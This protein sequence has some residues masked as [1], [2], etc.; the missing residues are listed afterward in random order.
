MRLDALD[1]FSS[2]IRCC[3]T[4]ASAHPPS[5][6]ASFSGTSSSSNAEKHVSRHVRHAKTHT[7]THTHTTGGAQ[8]EII[9][10]TRTTT[11]TITHIAPRSQALPIHHG[12]TCVTHKVRRTQ[13]QRQ[14]QQ[15]QQK[16]PHADDDTH[17][18]VVDIADGYPNAWREMCDRAGVD[19]KPSQRSSS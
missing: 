4:A 9:F 14:R 13:R 6:G 3:S 2:L 12:R 19:G 18:D 17:A 10:P 1:C 8:R 7:H 15:Q 11:R 5:C 16:T